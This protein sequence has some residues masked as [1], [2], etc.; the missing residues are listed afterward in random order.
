MCSIRG[1][2]SD[3]V[4]GTGSS[5]YER[6]ERKGATQERPADDMDVADFLNYPSYFD[7]DYEDDDDSGSHEVEEDLEHF[8][9]E[10]EIA[11]DIADAYDVGDMTAFELWTDCA[12]AVVDQTVKSVQSSVMIVF[13]LLLMHLL[14]PRTFV[15][16]S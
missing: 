10:V 9:Q 13:F 12:S 8:M 7:D 4:R 15:S 1:A 5:G 2:Y 16:P 6:K 14:L 11:P 3:I